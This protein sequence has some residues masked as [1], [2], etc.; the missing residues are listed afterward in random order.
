VSPN[1]AFPMSVLPKILPIPLPT[2]MAACG[3][4][5]L[6]AYFGLL[7]IGKPQPGDTVVISVAAG[8]VGSVMG[9]IAK[10]KRCRTVALPA[11][12]SSAS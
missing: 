10:L 2:T 9:Q 8:A 4:T 12:R 3:G 11:G 1:D 5:G 7:E 6:A